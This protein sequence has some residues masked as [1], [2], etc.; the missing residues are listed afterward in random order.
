[1]PA[2]HCRAV[3]CCG[4]LWRAVPHHV[5]VSKDGLERP[6][7]QCCLYCCIDQALI[8]PVGQPQGTPGQ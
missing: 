2:R 1:M 6:L 3:A 7:C 4:V 8:P 5:G